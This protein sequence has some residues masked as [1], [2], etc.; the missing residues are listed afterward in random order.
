MTAPSTGRDGRYVQP[1]LRCVKR[2]MRKVLHRICANCAEQSS[3]ASASIGPHPKERPRAASRRPRTA[4]VVSETW[5]RRQRGFHQSDPIGGADRNDLVVEVVS[6]VV[7]A[8]AIAVAD[9]DESA[10]TLL[11]HEREILRAH[12]RRD[13]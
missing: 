8:G 2:N 7:Q 9:K 6:R 10:G 3:R 1:F 4:E 13:V 11:E 12:D 5:L